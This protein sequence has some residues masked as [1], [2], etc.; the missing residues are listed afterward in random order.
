M[1]RAKRAARYVNASQMMTRFNALIRLFMY[2]FFRKVPM[3]S[4]DRERI[5]EAAREGQVVYVLAS[6]ARLDYV[7]YNYRFLRDGLPLSRFMPGL[8]MLRHQPFHYWFKYLWERARGLL[9]RVSRPLEQFQRI[10]AKGSPVTLYMREPETLVQWGERGGHLAPYVQ[11]LLDVQRETGRDVIFVPMMLVWKI[12]ITRYRRTLFDRVFGDPQAPGDT[13]KLF[14]FIR[15]RRRARV[16][17]LEPIRLSDV[18]AREEMQDLPADDQADS[19]RL[20]LRNSLALEEQTIHGPPLK[21]ARVIISEMLRNEDFRAAVEGHGFNWDVRTEGRVRRYLKEIAADFRF[22]SLES[23]ALTVSFITER[24]YKG[25]EVDEAGLDRIREAARK[26][27]LIITPSHRSH[28]DYLAISNILYNYGLIPPHIVAGNN[29]SFWPLGSIFRHCGAFFIRRHFR[30]NLLYAETLKWYIRKLLREGYWIEFFIEGGRSRTG[31]LLPPKFGVLKT[32][33]EAHTDGV[34]PE[35]QFVPLNVSYEKVIE[36]DSM[37]RELGGGEKKAENLSALIRSAKVFQSSY[38]RLYFEV[39]EPL[40]LTDEIARAGGAE[41]VNQDPESY[42]RFVN[43]MA[44][45]IQDGINKAAL[46]TPAAVTASALFTTAGRGFGKPRLYHRVGFFLHLFKERQARF[47]R[48]LAALQ[49]SRRASVEARAQELGVDPAAP[50]LCLH[51]NGQAY[52]EAL[53][54]SVEEAVDEALYLFSR[55]KLLKV[56]DFEGEEMVELQD[57]R[58]IKLDMY[59]NMSLHFILDESMV[60]L[61]LH[62]A[63]SDAPL[64]RF[65]LLEEMRF[66]SRLMKLEFIYPTERGFEENVDHALAFLTHLGLVSVD[67]EGAVSV[68]E[69]ADESLQWLSVALTPF[70]EAYDFVLAQVTTTLVEPTS[71]DALVRELVK[72]ARRAHMEGTVTRVESISSVSFK[73][74]LAW[75]VDQDLLRVNGKNVL[76]EGRDHAGIRD[77]REHIGRLM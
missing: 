23:F 73:N 46:V 26:G 62:H 66:L 58:R 38:G 1:T 61:V 64:S 25:V 15:N 59:K 2:L 35:L 13:R 47:S 30:G 8:S 63:K 16:S 18:L 14:G 57:K 67:E 39:G 33:L 5:Q 32:L 72:Q 74:A 60:A 71:S 10:V 3:S 44:H 27:P 34:V 29:L 20:L 41:V 69:G 48:T 24:I 42:R 53:G 11:A 31:K 36:D 70:L 37:A 76:P 17:V 54:R 49:S 43:Q 77:V 55:H 50:G 65:A 56:V 22:R 21:G 4:R 19:V 9:L 52:F 7:Y 40:S 51:E 6:R 75:L 45:R 68:L 28:F 12:G